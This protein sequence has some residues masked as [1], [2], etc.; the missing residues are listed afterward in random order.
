MDA[1]VIAIAGCVFILAL[2]AVA[3]LSLRY[4]PAEHRRG[5]TS[6][7]QNCSRRAPTVR[8]DREDLGRARGSIEP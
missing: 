8:L 4:S 1:V 3:F 7:A 2:L 5:E 6:I